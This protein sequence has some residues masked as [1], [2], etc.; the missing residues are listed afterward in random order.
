VAAIIL[1]AS[2][3]TWKGRIGALAATCG[4]ALVLLGFLAGIWIQRP[5]RGAP[6]GAANTLG[7]ASDASAPALGVRTNLQCA[8]LTG[9]R[10][11]RA[12]LSGADLRGAD[13][14]GTDL[15]YANLE[16][17]LLGEARRS[18]SRTRRIVAGLTRRRR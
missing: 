2:A 10:L 8:R 16:G 13:L 1:V 12:D 17:A 14:S 7:A 15:R 11:M 18:E 4:L 6:E 3:G 5:R 9:A